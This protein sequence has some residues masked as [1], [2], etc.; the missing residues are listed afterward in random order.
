MEGHYDCNKCPIANRELQMKEWLVWE[1]SFKKC[2]AVA[3]LNGKV[4]IPTQ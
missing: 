1:E 4:A 3:A 2:S